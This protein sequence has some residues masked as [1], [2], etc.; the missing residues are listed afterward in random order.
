MSYNTYKTNFMGNDYYSI[1][2]LPI[3]SASLSIVQLQIL[4]INYFFLVL[5]NN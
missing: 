3:K 1:D 5:N 4:F 2:L